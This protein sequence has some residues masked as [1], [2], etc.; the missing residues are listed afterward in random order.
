MRLTHTM[1]E[2]D[3][4]RASNSIRTWYG[5]RQGSG[6]HGTATNALRGSPTIRSLFGMYLS[7]ANTKLLIGYEGAPNKLMEIPTTDMIDFNAIILPRGARY[8]N[9]YDYDGEIQQRTFDNTFDLTFCLSAGGKQSLLLRIDRDDTES[10][11]YLRWI[12]RHG[13]IRYWLFASGGGN[14]RDCQ[15]PEFHTQQSVRIQRHIRLRWRQRKKAGIRAH[16]FNQTLRS[17]G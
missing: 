3:S 14:E 4:L 17:V 1:T 11:I 6:R 13:F 5:V 10:G 7:K 12:D 15:R 9:I 16:G 8:W 2:T